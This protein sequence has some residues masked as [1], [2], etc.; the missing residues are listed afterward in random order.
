MPKEL[1]VG[2]SLF[3]MTILQ[4]LIKDDVVGLRYKV[5]LTIIHIAMIYME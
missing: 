3:E 1:Q 5:T 4:V 2:Y